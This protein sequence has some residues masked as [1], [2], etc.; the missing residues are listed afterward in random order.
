MGDM[1]LGMYEGFFSLVVGSWDRGFAMGFLEVF[2]W[3]G[4]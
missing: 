3:G 1:I 4:K 2:T